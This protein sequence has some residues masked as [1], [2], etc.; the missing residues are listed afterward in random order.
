MCVLSHSAK[1]R[2]KMSWGRLQKTSYGRPHM[3]LYVTPKD[4][5]YQGPPDVEKWR[6]EDVSM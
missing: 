4:V 1:L 3:V 6:H 5:A 2:A